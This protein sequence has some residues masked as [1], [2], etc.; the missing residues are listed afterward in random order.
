MKQLV[1][2]AK[3]IWTGSYVP[4]KILTNKYLETLVDT[5]DEWIQ[6]TLG[7]KV[8]IPAQ[9]GHSFLLKADIDS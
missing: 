8:H 9:N 4:E 2:K 1:R 3:I 6:K 5:K 7:S